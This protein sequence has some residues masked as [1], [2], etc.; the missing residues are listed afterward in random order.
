[1]TEWEYT[2]IIVTVPAECEY[3]EAQAQIERLNHQMN[4][5]GKKGWELVVQARKDDAMV[6]AEN[7]G[8]L[9]PGSVYL[10][11]FKRPNPHQKA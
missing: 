8:K 10:Y 5:L 9:E 2:N 4:V 6:D 7:T 3:E 11:T 1:M